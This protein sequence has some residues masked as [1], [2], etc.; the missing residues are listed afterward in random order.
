MN[1][2][3]IAIFVMLCNVCTIFGQTKLSREGNG[4]ISDTLQSKNKNKVAKIE[5]YLIIGAD[6][7]TTYVDTT[8]SIKKD[9]KFNYLREDEFGL[10][11][12]SNLG[13]TYNRLIHDF[14]DN[15]SLPLFG[16]RAKHFNYF[17]ADDINYYHVPTPLT[18]LSYK[19]AF[20]QGQLLDA[21]FTVNTS[22]Q[23]NSGAA[24]VLYQAGFMQAK[25]STNSEWLF[26]IPQ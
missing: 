21:F 5:Q 19:T 4:S 26:K 17:E 3:F 16:A 2:V 15:R 8:L 25:P 20:E 22:E 9:Y 11:P 7:D 18:E 12:F 13:Q 6:R 10:L 1:K 14:K 23:F 24:A